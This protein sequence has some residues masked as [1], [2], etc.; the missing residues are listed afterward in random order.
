MLR[1]PSSVRI[2]VAQQTDA[3][4]LAAVFTESWSLAYSAILPDDHLNR[5][6][7][8]RD[9]QWWHMALQSSEPVLV[10]EVAGTTAGYATYGSSRGRGKTR[11]EIYEIYLSPVYQ[12]LGFGEHLFEACRGRLD[13]QGL[14]GLVVWA[15]VDNTQACHFYWRRGG[16]PATSVQEA[17]GKT[18]LEKVAF[19]WP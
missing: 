3:A 16:R 10:L 12:G 15:L 11:G 13:E 17:F 2:R 14:R 18:K 9:A 6:I 8:K 19:T 4:A 7:R 1:S 5:L